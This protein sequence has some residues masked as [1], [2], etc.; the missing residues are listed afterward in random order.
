MNPDS[1]PH[2]P[3]SQSLDPDPHLTD[4]DPQPCHELNNLY[5]LNVK[6]RILWITDDST[7]GLERI[8]GPADETHHHEAECVLAHGALAALL[9]GALAHPASHHKHSGLVLRNR[10]R[11]NRNFL[12]EPEPEP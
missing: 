10:N 6:I 11:R 12:P 7:H 3:V 1:D 4:A 2:E 8:V 9:A 5:H